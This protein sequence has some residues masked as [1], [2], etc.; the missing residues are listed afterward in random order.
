MSCALTKNQTH[1]LSVRK[2]MSNQL[3]HTGQDIP[4]EILA[5]KAGNIDPQQDEMKTKNA[6]SHC[7]VAIAT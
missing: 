7:S 6:S 2:M 4:K 1:E 5:Q 3:S